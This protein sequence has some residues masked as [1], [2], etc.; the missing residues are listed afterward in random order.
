MEETVW[1]FTFAFFIIHTQGQGWVHSFNCYRYILDGP[2]LITSHFH[3][4]YEKNPLGTLLWWSLVDWSDSL[5]LLSFHTLPVLNSKNT[6]PM[7]PVYVID[8]IV[9]TS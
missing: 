2:A 6:L 9:F 8:W 1:S 5:R 4:I 3:S 7:Y